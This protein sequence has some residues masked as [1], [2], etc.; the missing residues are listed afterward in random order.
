[1]IAVSVPANA[2]SK[3]AETLAA[4]SLPELAVRRTLL[5]TSSCCHDAYP[6]SLVCSQLLLYLYLHLAMRLRR[7]AKEKGLIDTIES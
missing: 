5:V 6:T 7:G 2:V 4:L 1:L 3:S